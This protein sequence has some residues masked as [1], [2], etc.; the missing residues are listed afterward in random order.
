MEHDS[1][2]MDGVDRSREPLSFSGC[3]GESPKVKQN[4]KVTGMTGVPR[5]CPRPS[6]SAASPVCEHYCVPAM[7]RSLGQCPVPYLWP[8][9][10]LL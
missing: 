9:V 5:S 6:A 4:T 2:H 8:V 1:R 3:R 10:P 7:L